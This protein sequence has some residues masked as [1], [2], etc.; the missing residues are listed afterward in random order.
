M[1]VSPSYVPMLLNDPTG[2]KRR[3]TYRRGTRPLGEDHIVCQI[4][5]ERLR[6]FGSHLR[7]AHNM[8]VREYRR[9]YPGAETISPSEREV[10]RALFSDRQGTPDEPQYWTR[11]RVVSSIQRWAAQRGGRPPTKSQWW[12]PMKVE[13]PLRR[14]R[15]RPSVYAVVSAFGTWSAAIKAAG[16]QPRG[17]GA[18]PGAI[19]SKCKRGHTLHGPKADVY[20]RPDGYLDC[21]ICGRQRQRAYYRRRK[22]SG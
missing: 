3:A 22:A 11:E 5:G 4:C 21:R 8:D 15:E 14:A 1:G 12:R 9:R 6:I 7:W 2:E 18:W 10:R 19:Q 13:S 20:V 17:R 16:F